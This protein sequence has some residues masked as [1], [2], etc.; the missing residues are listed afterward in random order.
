MRTGHAEFYRHA[1]GHG[2]VRRSSIGGSCGEVVDSETV[3]VLLRLADTAIHQAKSA[4]RNHV[5]LAS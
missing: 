5:Y 4:G 2:R 1:H 3:D